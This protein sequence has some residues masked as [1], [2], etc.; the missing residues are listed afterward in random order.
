MR[1]HTLSFRAGKRPLT[2]QR[3]LRELATGGR[4]AGRGARGSRPRADRDRGTVRP[5]DISG[6]GCRRLRPLVREAARPPARRSR[7]LALR[8]PDRVDRAQGRARLE[9]GVGSTSAV[10][11]R[12][13]RLPR[14]LL[15]IRREWPAVP[16]ALI[17]LGGDI[18]VFGSPPE[19]GSW[20][21][22]IADPRTRDGTLGTLASSDRAVATSGR[23]VRRFG[24]GLH[25]LIDPS[26]GTVS[27]Q[28][29][30]R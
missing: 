12:D 11:A 7:R 5:D 22:A 6:A 23:D 24:N 21:I 3:R 18:A 28:A 26:S 10:S 1:E 19:G 25:H 20:R 14:A 9:A 15:A 4:S 17:D 29:H 27:R 13:S 16:G 8:R 2:P 30:S